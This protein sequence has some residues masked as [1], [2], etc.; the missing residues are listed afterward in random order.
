VVDAIAIN[1]GNILLADLKKLGLQNGASFGSIVSG[2]LPIAALNK[3]TALENLRYIT[4]SPRP[5]IHTGSVT[6]QGDAAMNSDNAR[7]NYIVDGTGISIG[8]LSDSYDQ[9]P[10]INLDGTPAIGISASDDVA[11]NDLPAGGVNVLDDS[12]DCSLSSLDGRCSDE[13][14]AMLQIIH[15]V[16]PGANLLFHTAMGGQVSFHDAILALE[17]AGA[18]IIVDDLIYPT[19]PML[20]DGIVAQ[21]VDQV[22]GNGT[23]YFSAAGNS[24]QVSYASAFV[25]SG[26]DLCIDLGFGTGCDILVGRMH[27]FDSGGGIDVF[28]RI[29]VPVGAVLTIAYQWNET[30]GSIHTGGAALIDHDIS[31]F[32]DLGPGPTT[33]VSF[34]TSNDNVTSGEPWE[35]LQYFNDGTYGTAF[36][37]AITHDY[38]DSIAP[39]TATFMKSVFFG[40]GIA[41]NEHTTTSG[42][43]NSTLFGHANAAGAEAVG[44]ADYLDTPRNGIAPPLL[45][46]FSSKGGT[47][48]LFDTTGNPIPA[49]VRQKPEIVAPD[50]VNT[51]FFPTPVIPFF[52]TSAAAPHAAGAAA[53]M[54][55][56]NPGLTPF[57]IY[58]ALE[59]TTVDMNGAGFDHDSGWGLVDADAAVAAVL[60]ANL[61]PTA[62]FTFTTSD[63]TANFT[64]MSTDSGGTITGWSWNFGDGPVPGSSTSPNPSNTYGSADTYTVTLT[65]TDDDGA[66]NSTNQSVTVTAPSSNT[67]PSATF[68]YS[69]TGKNCTFTDGSSDPDFGDSVITWSWNFGDSGTSTSQSPSHSYS[70]VGT[71]PVTLTVTDGEDSGTASVTF[72]IKNGNKTISGS[73]NSGG[74]GGGGDIGGSEKGRKKCNDGMDND[75]DDLIDGADPDCK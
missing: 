21:A 59:S 23:A 42:T 31:L 15:D 20:L 69:C 70:A 2:R 18:D 51:T 41:I 54:L 27:D 58:T 71:Y 9:Q 14:R 16:A 32:D 73:S 62:S 52:G 36:N 37:I 50:G 22:V 30:W 64:D 6:S 48:I 43:D 66:T 47:P 4:A 55:H 7:S 35:I 65:V 5:I 67:P 56:A 29:T 8:V 19:E 17:A 63:L 40:S 24:G 60:G 12:G 33:F 53:L 39:A 13:G 61:P 75:G 1:D 49:L 3:V 25:D 26:E 46:S 74:S 10:T 45:E 11:S 34:G 57:Q 38:E 44:A 72:S 28:Q 68:T